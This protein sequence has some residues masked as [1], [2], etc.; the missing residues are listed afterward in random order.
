MPR[1]DA[2]RFPFGHY[3]K[4]A[5]ENYKR[6]AKGRKSNIENYEDRTRRVAE[7]VRWLVSQG[8]I[9]AEC[10]CERCFSLE[11]YAA[12]WHYWGAEA[13]NDI[14]PN[15]DR[16][17]KWVARNLKREGAVERAPLDEDTRWGLLRVLFDVCWQARKHDL[18]ERLDDA[19]ELPARPSSDEGGDQ[20]GVDRGLEA[21][22]DILEAGAA[23]TL[24][25]NAAALM[26]Y[27][28][29]AFVCSTG[30]RP[31]STVEVYPTD[32]SA[33]GVRV[34]VRVN[35][36]RRH[37]D[38]RPYEARLFDPGC[39][40]LGSFFARRATLCVEMGIDPNR[41]PLFFNTTEASRLFRPEL[42]I[43]VGCKVGEDQV[44]KA[45]R[46]V[47][48]GAAS[49]AGRSNRARDIRHHLA[50]RIFEEG[51]TV[52]DAA[53]Q[54][55]NTPAVLWRWYA[56]WTK[57]RNLDR[58]AQKSRAGRGKGDVG[59]AAPVGSIPPDYAK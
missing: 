37:R 10:P 9:K 55:G 27:G 34:R 1:N 57:G 15:P 42:G 48:E 24:D 5:L 35:K 43:H 20:A 19:G 47:R 40:H 29:V 21:L 26:D 28:M 59:A 18:A 51:G 12:L 44:S 30:A 41:T 52:E 23:R 54:L 50:N 22:I 6:H 45:M 58:L 11:S 38:G 56:D 4:R 16:R 36:A 3:A 8:K 2:G 31:L 14:R 25:G 32:F 7:D 13:K 17:S 53:A 33:D 39:L 46:I 49:P